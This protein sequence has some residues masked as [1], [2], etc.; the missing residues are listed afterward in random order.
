MVT[1]NGRTGTSD[2]PKIQPYALEMML[3]A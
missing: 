2:G 1:G 3:L